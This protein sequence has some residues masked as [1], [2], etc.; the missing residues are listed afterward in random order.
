MRC[1]S[2]SYPTFSAMPDLEMSLPTWPDIDGRRKPEMS[3]TEPEVETGSENNHERKEL[4]M[5]F[6]RIPPHYRLCPTQKCH[7]RHGP[8]STDV[9]NPRCRQWNR[10]WKPE[11]EITMNGKSWR[12]HSNDLSHI[13]GHA[14]LKYDTADTARHRPISI[15]QNVDENRK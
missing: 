9:G 6:Q 7:C 5:R 1:N 12:C 14:K 3:A 13:F 4:A 8:T 2:N 15:T 11:V 10:K